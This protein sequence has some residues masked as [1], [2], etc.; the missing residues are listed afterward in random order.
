VVA[1]SAAATGLPKKAG[2]SRS[3]PPLGSLW[4][5]GAID[6]ATVKAVDDRRGNGGSVSAAGGPVA[7]VGCRPAEE[8]A[9]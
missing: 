9:T 1:P 3:A 4:T 2:R 8:L 7:L 5:G 6:R